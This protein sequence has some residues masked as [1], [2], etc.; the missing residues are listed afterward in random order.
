L[1][2]EKQIKFDIYITGSNSKLLS[3]E[4]STLLTGRHRDIRVMP[5]SLTEFADVS[6]N[7][8]LRDAFA[9][10]I[11]IGG[12]GIIIPNINNEK[13]VNQDL[14]M[15]L[16]DTINKD[17]KYRHRNK[18]NT[19]INRLIEYVY[20]VIGKPVSSVNIENYFKSNKID[21]TRK[22]IDSYLN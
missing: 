2:E 16:E 18:N 17:I 6:Q 22:T 8:S 19:L 12:L 9:K 7:P 21:I 4:L 13:E 20:S 15:V 10:Y 14:R 1:Y 3:T 11:N 5:L